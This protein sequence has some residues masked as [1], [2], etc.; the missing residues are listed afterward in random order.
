MSSLSFLFR[1]RQDLQ[2]SNGIKA[3]LYSI[4]DALHPS[5]FLVLD[6]WKMATVEGAFTCLLVFALGA[7]ASGLT[8]L[9]VSPMAISLYAG[10]LNATGL[11]LFIFAAAPASGGHLNPSITM[12]T[13]FAGLSTLPRSVLYIV[14]ESITYTHD[15]GVGAAEYPLPCCRV[16]LEE[17]CVDSTNFPALFC[18]LIK[19]WDNCHLVRHCH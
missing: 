2:H 16:L 8:T 3:P 14:Y 5:G 7:G 10:L 4:R 19:V 9:Q 12:A 15:V 18:D 17:K 11:A 13:F 6:N 1:S